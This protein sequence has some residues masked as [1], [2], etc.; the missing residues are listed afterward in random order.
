MMA[1]ADPH[2]PPVDG[3]N[4]PD[5]DGPLRLD[6]VLA[7]EYSALRPESSFDGN[8]AELFSRIH[9]NNDPLSAVCISGG[10]IRSAT[11]A[12]G[13]IQGLAERGLLPQFDYLSTVSGGGY[14]G[15]WLTAWIHRAGSIWGIVPRRQ[16]AAFAAQPSRWASSRV[17]RT[18]GFSISSTI[19]LFTPSRQMA[20]SAP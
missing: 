14:I 7:G 3:E 6:E 13:A 1:D 15:G 16:A 10:G 9:R 4:S 19:S 8:E 2:R 18:S 17:S 20:E 12:L 11:F 5:Q